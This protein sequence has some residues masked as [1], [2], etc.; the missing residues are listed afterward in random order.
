MA[1]HEYRKLCLSTLRQKLLNYLHNK[2][3]REG[4]ICYKQ[5]LLGYWSFILVFVKVKLQEQL[6]C[7]ISTSQC[8]Y[9]VSV[10]GSK[11]GVKA[12]KGGFYGSSAIRLLGRFSQH[13]QFR[14]SL[15]RFQA[16]LTTFCILVIRY[17]KQLWFSTCFRGLTKRRRGG[18]KRTLVL[19]PC[20][21]VGQLWPKSF[22]AT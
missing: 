6:W 17:P 16:L 13:L 10:S 4:F 5:S 15:F 14:L 18:L 20:L 21:I 11:I 8:V 7:P 9:Q 3:Q 12:I 19:I 1:L 2:D 22:E